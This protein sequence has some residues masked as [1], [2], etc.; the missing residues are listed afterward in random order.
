METAVWTV[1]FVIFSNFLVWFDS[2]RTGYSR[3]PN[4]ELSDRA[5]RELEAREFANEEEWDFYGR[6]RSGGRAMA[7]CVDGKE[8]ACEEMGEG[9]QT[10][11]TGFS[12]LSW[13][14]LT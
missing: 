1:G 11:I 2:S 9:S 5:E 10:F 4:C 6:G 13:T 12:K 14:F 3:K 7:D 8:E